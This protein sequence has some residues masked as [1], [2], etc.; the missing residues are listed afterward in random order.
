MTT[1]SYLYWTRKQKALTH[2]TDG[3]HTLFLCKNPDPNHPC[4]LIDTDL[5]RHIFSYLSEWK[6]VWNSI[7]KDFEKY[8]KRRVH[9]KFN[10]VHW[11]VQGEK[12]ESWCDYP[13]KIHKVGN[14]IYYGSLDSTLLL[15]VE[16]GIEP[17]YYDAFSPKYTAPLI[18]MITCKPKFFCVR[19]GEI[20]LDNK[21]YYIGITDDQEDDTYNEI[22]TI[23]IPHYSINSERGR[24][25]LERHKLDR[26]FDGYILP[27]GHDDSVSIRDLIHISEIEYGDITSN[28][29]PPN[30]YD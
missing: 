18:D 6:I 27:V 9:S 12:L 11:Y 23:E 7:I 17:K 26:F 5:W 29:I 24:T 22:A 13:E 4:H 15:D 10:T 28:S 20:D 30:F 19:L 16:I 25:I 14:A 8:V 2:V 3:K 21:C 1:N